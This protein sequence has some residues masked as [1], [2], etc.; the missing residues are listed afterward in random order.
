MRHHVIKWGQRGRVAFPSSRYWRRSE[1]NAISAKGE[2]SWNVLERIIYVHRSRSRRERRQRGREK[3][4]P[5]NETTGKGRVEVSKGRGRKRKR[6][7][8]SAVEFVNHSSTVH[9]LRDPDGVCL[10]ERNRCTFHHILRPNVGPRLFTGRSQ[11]AFRSQ[12]LPSAAC[13]LSLFTEV[14][15]GRLQ[16]AYRR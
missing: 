8:K 11:L 16:V 4:R 5:G 9:A 2:T 13:S 6:Q 3:E 10:S 7:Q 14:F 1:L 12:R 15:S